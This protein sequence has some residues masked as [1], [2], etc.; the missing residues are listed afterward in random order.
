MAEQSRTWWV[1]G[2]IVVLVLVI[3]GVFMLRGLGGGRGASKATPV[4]VSP[5]PTPAPPEAEEAGLPEG[6]TLDTSDEFVRQVV[7]SISSNPTLVTWLANKDLVRRFVASV[8]MLAHGKSPRK[9]LGFARP[10]G[11]FRVV[12]RGSSLVADP[13]SF[14]RYDLLADIVTS[15]DTEGSVEAI[16]RLKPLIDE[17]YRE[18]GKPG[19]TFEETLERAIVELLET[20]VVPAG[21]PLKEKVVTYVYTDP[22]LE[23]LSDA[24]RQLLRMGPRNVQRV[25]EKLRELAVALGIPVDSLPQ[26]STWEPSRG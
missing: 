1:I 16:R 21:V 17:A 24:Q 23:D 19:T 26:P 6:V 22:R 14:H 12:K 13:R 25:Q 3:A 8:D 7:A 2:G 20:P 18:I 15:L 10:R 4:A 9:L 5:S 11:R